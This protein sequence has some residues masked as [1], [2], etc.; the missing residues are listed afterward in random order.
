MNSCRQLTIQVIAQGQTEP[1]IL[2]AELGATSTI[3]DLKTFLLASAD[4]PPNYPEHT[5]SL[6]HDGN[7]VTASDDTLLSAVGVKDGDMLSATAQPNQTPRPSEPSG[8]LPSASQTTPDLAGRMEELRQH[9]L[10]HRPTRE[11]FEQNAGALFR[12]MGTDAESVLQNPELFARTWTSLERRRREEMENDSRLDQD[13]N[14][15]N[16]KEIMRRIQQGQIEQDIAKV[17]EENPEMFGS[18]TMLYIKLEVNGHPVK[19]FV[20][21]GAQATILSPKCA[22]DC[23]IINKVDSRFAGIARGVGTAKILGRIHRVMVKIGSPDTGYDDVPCSFTVME[24]KGVDM[25]LGLDMLKRYQASIDLS[26]NSL[27]FP[28]GVKIPFLPEHEIPKF[29][30]DTIPGSPE[31]SKAQGD[32]S[33]FKGAGQT[34]GTSTASSTSSA[35]ATRP[36]NSQ[37]PSPPQ[38]LNRAPAPSQ[39]GRQQ[40]PQFPQQHIDALTGMGASP[41]QAVALLQQCSGNLDLAASMLFDM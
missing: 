18:V 26:Q 1:A 17:M 41:Q 24:G 9:I 31:Q 23:G 16:Q 10:S 35:N 13:V 3:A 22:E 34:L 12:E 15:E 33:N 4:L 27:V 39:L 7:I 32:P 8:T 11:A 29:D 5:W 28:N 38:S 36:S 14:E 20:D 40:T 2:S 37:R 6:N 25:L 21:S 30:E 19:A